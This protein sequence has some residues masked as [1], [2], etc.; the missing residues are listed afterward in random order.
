MSD[1]IV[2][3]RCESDDGILWV[4]LINELCCKIPLWVT[5]MTTLIYAIVWFSRNM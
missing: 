3:K 2:C 1:D 5:L 4:K